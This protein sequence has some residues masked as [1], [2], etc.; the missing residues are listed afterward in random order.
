MTTCSRRSVMFSPVWA[1]LACCCVFP[2]SAQTS[3]GRDIARARLV[4]RYCHA[5][6]IFAG[7][8]ADER[9]RILDRFDPLLMKMDSAMGEQEVIVAL[10]DSNEINAHTQFLSPSRSLICL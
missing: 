7:G 4:Q 3:R 2:T 5:S 9:A 8:A 6:E 10:V 1:V